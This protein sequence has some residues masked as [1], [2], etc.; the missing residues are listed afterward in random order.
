[1]SNSKPCFI[2][3]DDDNIIKRFGSSSNMSIMHNDDKVRGHGYVS[4][5]NS[6]S[7]GYSSSDDHAPSASVEGDGDDDDDDDGDF[8]PAA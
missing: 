7:K 1:M 2:I 6:L 3:H 4:N 8:A 5:S